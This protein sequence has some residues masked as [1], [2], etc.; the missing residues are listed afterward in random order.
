MHEESLQGNPDEDR[1]KK[2]HDLVDQHQ[3]LKQEMERV[4]DEIIDVLNQNDPIR[5]KGGEGE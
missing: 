2:L 4:E 5:K 1:R 3:N